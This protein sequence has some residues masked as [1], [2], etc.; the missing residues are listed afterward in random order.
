M[1]VQRGTA[2]NTLV[3]DNATQPLGTPTVVGAIDSFTN[4]ILDTLK[5]WEGERRLHWLPGAELHF[6][7]R[8]KTA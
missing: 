1:D 4:S 6:P 8:K 2:V 7:K 5:E 3:P